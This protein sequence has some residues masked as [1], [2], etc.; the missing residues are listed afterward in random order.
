[1]TLGKLSE[2]LKEYIH[3][4]VFIQWDLIND[5]PWIQSIGY[6]VKRIT[7]NGIDY[8]LIA[9]DY[10]LSNDIKMEDFLSVQ[11]VNLLMLD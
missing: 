3:T 4:D 7:V 6:A 9:P 2:R 8:P 11:I 10:L 5:G 1:M